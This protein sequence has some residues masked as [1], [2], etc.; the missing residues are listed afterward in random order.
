MHVFATAEIA[1]AL[2]QAAITFGMAALFL[3]LYSRYRKPHF[4]WW[5]VAWGLYGLRLAA[6]I[7]FLSSSTWAWLYWHQVATGWTA[8]GL[9]WAALVF[10]RQVRLQPAYVLA[11]LFPLVWS[12]IAIFKLDNFVL[13]AVPA[14]LFLSMTTLWTGWVFLQYYR[15]TGSTA[16][17]VL[18]GTFL[19]WGLHHLDYPLLRARGAWNPWGYYLDALFLLAVGAGVLL[20]VIEELRQ[21]VVTMAALSGDLQG[22]DREDLLD[23]LLQGPLA[24]RGVRGA[25]LF[26]QS[27][28]S[29]P[30]R[31]VGD[32]LAWDS[33]HAAPAMVRDLVAEALRSGHPVLRGSATASPDAPPFTAVLPLRGHERPAGALVVVADV[34]AP[35]AALDDRVLIAVGEQ[36]GAAL[37]N[38]E[39]YRTLQARTADLERLSVRMIQQH[40][41]Q[42][43]RLARELHD[44]TAQVFSAL[45]LQLGSLQESS[46]PEVSGRFEKL[47]DLVN[48]GR[49]SIR[50]VTEDLRPSLLDDLGLIP[51][52]RALVSDFREWSG[53]ATRF[54][55]PD[56]LPPLPPDAELA[57]FRS[58]QEGLSN[59]ARHANAEEVLV[60]VTRED[61]QVRLLVSDDGIGLG[62]GDLDRVT[63]GPGRSGLF[64]MRERI[65]ALGG[66]VR[67]SAG[68]GT[69][70]Q[71]DVEL[72]AGLTETN[73]G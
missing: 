43:Q 39:L 65:T 23:A 10:S 47:L 50:N 71:L 5:A 60:R 12:Y 6:I 36:I 40:E 58:V 59:V 44:E 34:A 62:A 33:R 8:L 28:E 1:A 48:A 55:A 70:M 63:T 7:S 68:A 46:A 16:G 42:R 61:G 15:R 54:E 25:A 9:L 18:A 26:H 20:L 24:L 21:G 73:H 27:D 2:F 13:A 11:L 32:C 37:E 45:K 49:R 66:T 56:S 38:A 29:S 64:G 35:F 31:C 17:A 72:P 14:V 51:A 3:F 53:L 19:L 57:L 69:G 22:R 52:L 4:F 30:I 67:F 41:E